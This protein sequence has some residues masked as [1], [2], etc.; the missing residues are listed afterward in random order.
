VVSIE[1]SSFHS[2]SWYFIF[3]FKGNLLFK[4]QKNGFRGLKQSMWL[5]HFNGAPTTN[6]ND[7]ANQSPDSGNQLAGILLI[8]GISFP[9]KFKLIVSGM[10][11][12]AISQ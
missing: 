3:T 8:A 9:L 10:P 7:S 1:R 4:L 11:I 2:N 6:K 5:I 12:S